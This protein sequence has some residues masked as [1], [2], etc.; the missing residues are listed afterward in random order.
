MILIMP[1][2]TSKRQPHQPY[3]FNHDC[4]RKVRYSSKDKAEET[5]RHQESLH[6]TLI[7]RVYQC[8]ACGGWHLTRADQAS[9][10][11]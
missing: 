11:D 1:R 2:R 8:P 7:L 10:E 6:L 9:V 3:H 4:D 5:K